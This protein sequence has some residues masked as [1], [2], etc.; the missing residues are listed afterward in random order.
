MVEGNLDTTP[1]GLIGG[2]TGLG[3][4]TFYVGPI[5]E[6]QSHPLQY[7]GTA[8]YTQKNAMSGLWTYYPRT[9]METNSL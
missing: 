8:A 3:L 2:G 6:R 9:P 4:G 1:P 7:A 5:A